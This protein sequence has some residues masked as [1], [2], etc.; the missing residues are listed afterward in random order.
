MYDD[1]DEDIKASLAEASLDDFSSQADP[2]TPTV[3]M[4]KVVTEPLPVSLPSTPTPTKQAQRSRFGL[5]IKGLRSLFEREETSPTF[6]EAVQSHGR[7]NHWRIEG[8]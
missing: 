4:A 3:V 7:G 8:S 6:V 5:G 1:E 2:E